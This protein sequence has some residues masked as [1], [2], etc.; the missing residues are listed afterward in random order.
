MSSS[1]VPEV[2]PL[3]DLVVTRGD[4]VPL[5]DQ[6]AAL[7]EFRRRC[8]VQPMPVEE[9]LARLRRIE[10]AAIVWAT[11]RGDAGLARLKEA[12]EKALLEAIR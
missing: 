5:P 9:E 7:P 4:G 11:V 8:L 3:P 2:K 12:A 6:S 10:T 1:A